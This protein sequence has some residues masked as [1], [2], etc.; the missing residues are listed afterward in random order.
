MLYY[1]VTLE[2]K[3][4]LIKSVL[5][6]HQ[7]HQRQALAK[8]AQTLQQ[9]SPKHTSPCLYMWRKVLTKHLHYRIFF[10]EITPGI[11]G[12]RLYNAM[13][14]CSSHALRLGCLGELVSGKLFL[15]R[16]YYQDRLLSETNPL[17]LVRIKYQ[18]VSTLT[19]FPHPRL[20]VF[21]ER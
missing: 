21:S 3:T 15:C 2:N 13:F 8:I 16:C 9:V 10:N 11:L 14:K 17:L 7:T 1:P 20:P 19:P 5:Q 12:S 6:Y 18:L 4:L